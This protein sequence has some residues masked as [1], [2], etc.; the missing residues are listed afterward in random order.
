MTLTVREAVIAFLNSLTALTD[1]VGTRI[2][3]SDPSQL[4]A[5]PCVVVRCT[6][7]KYTNNIYGFAGASLATI[8]IG[9]LAIIPGRA[10]SVAI[11]EVVRNNYQGFQGVQSGVA[12]L[13][14][15]L[16][17]ESDDTFENVDGSDNWIY[18]TPVTY[19]IYHRVPMPTNVTQTPD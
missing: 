5:Y 15:L 14:C 12:V 2:Y 1:I 18:E 4:A 13:R 11:A 10:T 7:R 16:D 9:C 6:N 17:D 8:E 3:D 19:Q